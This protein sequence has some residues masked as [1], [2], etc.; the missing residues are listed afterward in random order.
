M[1]TNFD[2]AL[3][4]WLRVYTERWFIERVII[5]N[6][7]PCGPTGAGAQ[8]SRFDTF[9]HVSRNPRRVRLVAIEGESSLSWG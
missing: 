8:G 4:G 1:S 3:R 6:R 9:T 2:S 7:R 5:S